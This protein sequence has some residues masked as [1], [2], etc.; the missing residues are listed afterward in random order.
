MQLSR[1]SGGPR[2][3]L[4]RKY[5]RASK[6]KSYARELFLFPWLWHEVAAP[7]L[8]SRAIKSYFH[9][10]TVIGTVQLH[11]VERH[12]KDISALGRLCQ[13]LEPWVQI[14]GVLNDRAACSVT[15]F[16]E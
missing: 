6:T 14:V 13:L 5:A 4:C 8:D 15:Q 11:I 7:G 12:F 9:T 1:L 2:R 10:E 16:Q 3:T